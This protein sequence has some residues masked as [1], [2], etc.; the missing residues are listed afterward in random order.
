MTAVLQ[1]FALLGLA[2]CAQAGISPIGTD[3]KVPT[4]APL[5]QE[6]TPAVVNIAVSSGSP[7]EDNP[8]LQDPF[9]R[10]F[11][12][13]QERPEPRMSAGSGVIIDAAKGYVLTNHHVVRPCITI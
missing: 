13:L 7:E 8:L 5:L 1:F 6:V 2:A 3:G 11:F 4:L 10:R 9:F 12:G